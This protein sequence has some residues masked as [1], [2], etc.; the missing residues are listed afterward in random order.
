MLTIRNCSCCVA[1]AVRCP[2]GPHDSLVAKK[3]AQIEYVTNKRDNTSTA[4]DFTMA[5]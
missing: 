5:E 1:V 3:P 2:K 4:V